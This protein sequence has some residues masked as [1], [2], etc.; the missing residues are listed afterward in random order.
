LGFL[1]WV[2]GSVVHGR[3]DYVNLAVFS[4]L[5]LYR[6][7]KGR[8]YFPA[9]HVS[10]RVE[11][12]SSEVRSDEGCDEGDSA[13]AMKGESNKTDA[14]KVVGGCAAGCGEAMR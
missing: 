6:P 12:E 1:A 3:L 5:I 11:S 4:S 7:L 8:G 10:G 9:P 13:Y 14:M 2:V